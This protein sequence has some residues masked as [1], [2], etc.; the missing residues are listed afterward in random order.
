MYH[1]HVART[2]DNKLYIGHT[3]HLDRRLSEHAGGKFGAKFLKDHGKAFQ[4]VHTEAF[5]SRSA[6]MRRERQLKRWSR[7]KKEAL[8]RGEIEALTKL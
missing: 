1:V 3:G 2:D 7:A 4:V 6:A 8:V 5:E